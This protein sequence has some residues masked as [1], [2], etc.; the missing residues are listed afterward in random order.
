MD[1]QTQWQLLIDDE[2]D[3]PSFEKLNIRT[4]KPEPHTREHPLRVHD[5]REGE[6]R[7]IQCKRYVSTSRESSGVN[8]RNHCPGCLYSRHVD[9]KT[10]GDRLAECHSKMA[11]I[12]LTFKHTPK[13]YGRS[14]QGELMLIHECAGC[15]KISIN[16]IAGDDDPHAL[17]RVFADSAVLS[18][19]IQQQLRQQEI[20]LLDSGNRTMVFSQLFGWQAIVDELAIKEK[21]LLPIP[22]EEE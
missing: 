15:G 22:L 19:H 4:A 16:R 21:I 8:N 2:M 3:A 10:P 17:Y 12:G 6:F 7:C 14:F 11:P 20:V 1:K 18:P 5:P 13:K 9:L